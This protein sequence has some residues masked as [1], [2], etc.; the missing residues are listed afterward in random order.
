MKYLSKLKK[1]YLLLYKKKGGVMICG[2]LNCRTGTE[3]DFIQDDTSKYLLLFNFY[4]IDDTTKVRKNQDDVL[5]ARE[6]ELLDL[7]ISY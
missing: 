1:I 4:K 6:K 3:F 7:C 2:D 5:D